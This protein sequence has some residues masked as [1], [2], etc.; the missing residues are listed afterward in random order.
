MA[1]LE[2]RVQVLFDPDRYRLLETM[3]K[4]TGSSVG[5]LVRNAV[6]AMVEARLADDRSARLAAL[7][8]LWAS[9]DAAPHPAPTDWEAVKDSFERS[10]PPA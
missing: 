7:E 9:G 5:A 4:R 10:F 6:D 8:R 3:A 1:V 2:R